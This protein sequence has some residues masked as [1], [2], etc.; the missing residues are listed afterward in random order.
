MKEE[1]EKIGFKMKDV[2][3]W[4]MWR[5]AVRRVVKGME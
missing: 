2:L 5:D 3:N 4:V 1:K